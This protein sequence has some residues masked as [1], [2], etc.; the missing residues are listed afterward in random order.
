M[1]Q[2]RFDIAIT[3]INYN[4]SE[5]TKK[6]VQS[7]LKHTTT[8]LSFEVIVIDNASNKSDYDSLVHFYKRIAA[9]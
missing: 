3:L 2:K 5:Y 7:I 8:S 1:T 9:G 6:C 4:S